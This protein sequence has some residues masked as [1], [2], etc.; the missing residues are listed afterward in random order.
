[1]RAFKSLAFALALVALP[2]AAMAGGAVQLRQDVVVPGGVVTLGD[3]FADAGPAAGVVVARTQPGQS[4]VL[5]ATQVQ[6]IARTN[7]VDWG[8]FAGLR[9]ITVQSAAPEARLESAA[10][11]KAAAVRSVQVLAYAHSLSA[12]D[13]VQAQDLI[14]SREAVAAADAPRNPDA[15]IGM[16]VRR[17]LREG[18]A[19][20]LRDISAPIVIKRDDVIS[21]T[22]SLNGMSLTLQ[23]KALTDAAAGQNLTVMNTVSKKVIQAVATAPGQAVVGPEAEQIKAAARLAPSRLALR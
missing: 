14:W 17:P 23:A 9:R 20:S 2:A 18:D 15:V 22:F 12:G 16:A 5:D 21:V 13:I 7:G 8:N 11:P 1:M 4:V 10:A 19:V 3:L 6:I